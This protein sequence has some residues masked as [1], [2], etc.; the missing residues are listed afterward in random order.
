MNRFIRTVSWIPACAGMTLKLCRCYALVIWLVA[1]V[2]VVTAQ[3]PTPR[4]AA[5]LQIGD[6]G[7][8]TTWDPITATR[9]VEYHVA[10]FIFDSMVVARSEGDFVLSLAKEIAISPDGLSYTFVLHKNLAWSDKT[11]LT[12]KDV[13]FTLAVLLNPETDNYDSV[14]AKYIEDVTCINPQAIT[15]SLSRPFYSPLAL[16]AFKILPKHKLAADYLK[17]AHGFCQ[18]PIGCGPFMLASKSDANCSLTV[19]P[20]FQQRTKPLLD[21]VTLRFY[22]QKETALEDLLRKK[23]QLVTE[24][25]PQDIATVERKNKEFALV[26]YQNPT[27]HF[28]AFNHRREHRYHALFSDYR[29][30]RALLQAIDRQAIL[31]KTFYAGG[32]QNQAHVVISGLFP[33][34][35]WA[36]NDKI[37]PHP[38]N[39]AYAEQLLKEL[40]SRKGYAKDREQFWSKEHEGRLTLTLLCPLGDKQVE[41]AC[42]EMVGTWNRLGLSVTLEKLDDT[43]IQQKSHAEHAFDLVYSQY[44]FDNTLNLF[45][46]FDPARAGNGQS[47]FSGYVDSKLV[48]LFYQLHAT[49]NPWLLRAI[50]HKIHQ[51]LHDDT[52]HLFLWQ[53]DLYAA[54][55]RSLKNL[56]LHP[57]YL[58][59]FP[60]K[61]KIIEK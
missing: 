46:L 53:L 54:H 56:K 37:K 15:I 58:I 55:H 44:A 51:A 48:E 20:E 32:K 45:P 23:I 27:V 31:N 49:L 47:N 12:T 17:R 61:W 8:P 4:Q 28:I 2:T 57:R 25:S 29:F 38:Y 30:R 6:I 34:N 60:E 18:N 35:S 52:V 16:F 21:K 33:A 42:E 11:P 1:N 50:C 59:N 26:R 10:Q 36:Y 13:E 7:S 9:P 43:T 22:G 19:N 14:L 24:V 41:A 3:A 5:V 40:L 39:F